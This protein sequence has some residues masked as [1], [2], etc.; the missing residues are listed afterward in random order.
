MELDDYYETDTHWKQERLDKVIR[1]MSSVMNFQY[2]SFEYMENVY[3][4]FC[5]F[6]YHKPKALTNH[7]DT[8]ASVQSVLREDNSQNPTSAG[9]WAFF[10]L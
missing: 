5:R 9:R 10:R 1:R 6:P 3:D 2:K 8:R 4:K 7:A